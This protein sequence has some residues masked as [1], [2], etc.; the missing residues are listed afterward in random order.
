MDLLN[1]S[2]FWDLRG[3]GY[4]DIPARSYYSTPTTL[5]KSW[6]SVHK[7]LAIDGRSQI[8]GV[9]ERGVIPAIKVSLCL[10]PHSPG[11][12]HGGLCSLDMLQDIGRGR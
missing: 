4:P 12:K 1:N 7:S 5:I 11:G 9:S 6:L 2:I 3:V 8:G 10:G